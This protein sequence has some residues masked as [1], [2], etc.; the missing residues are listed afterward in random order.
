MLYIMIGKGL[1]ILQARELQMA[2]NPSTTLPELESDFHLR[3]ELRIARRVLQE[4]ETEDPKDDQLLFRSQLILMC[5]AGVPWSSPCTT[6][7]VED[8][9]PRDETVPY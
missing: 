1:D 8:V 4:P 9:G 6:E 5:L 2:K 7:H 3:T